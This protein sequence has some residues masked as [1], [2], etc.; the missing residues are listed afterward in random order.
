MSDMLNIIKDLSNIGPHPGGSK[1]EK[2]IAKYFGDSIKKYCDN[3]FFDEF[4][5]FDIKNNEKK[6]LNVI[7]EFGNNPGKKILICT[8][9]DTL[10]DLDQVVDLWEKK[11]K[12]VYSVPFIE[13]ANEPDSAIAFLIYFVK[14]LS[15]SRLNKNVLIVGFGAQEDWDATLKKNYDHDIPMKSVKK[16]KRLRYLVGSRHFV[17]SNGIKDIDSVIAIDAVGIGNPKIISQDSF[18]PSTLNS[19]L[20]KGL[21]D[22]KIRGFRYKPGRRSVE[23]IGCDHLP[24]R[25]SGVPST[26]IFASRGEYVEKSFLGYILNHDNIPNYGTIRDNYENLAKETT[27]EELLRTFDIISDSLLNYIK[28]RPL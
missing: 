8:N 23:L 5:Y 2:D 20:L 21:E 24:F 16:M 10:R 4:E 25:V 3:L 11:E 26:W 6:S 13:G 18:G 12:D 27:D 14:K 7:G 19:E 28:E 1:Q 22:L 9:I 15:E 17:L